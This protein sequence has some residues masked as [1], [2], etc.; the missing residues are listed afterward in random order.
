M[1]KIGELFIDDTE[2]LPMICSGLQ[3]VGDALDA[4]ARGEDG[5]EAAL[6][7]ADKVRKIITVLD[8]RSA[9]AAAIS[10]KADAANLAEQCQEALVDGVDELWRVVRCPNPNTVKEGTE[11]D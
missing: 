9:L 2:L 6:G 4:I 1:T 7:E 3:E 11:N 5:P 10:A 8:R